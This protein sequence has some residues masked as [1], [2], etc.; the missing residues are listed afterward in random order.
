VDTDLIGPGYAS[1]YGLA[2][3]VHERPWPTKKGE[4]IYADNGVRTHG[5]VSYRTI[6]RGE[7]HGCHR[8]FNHQALRLTGF[9]LQHRP[10]RR[11]GPERVGYERRI[12]WRGRVLKLRVDDRGY[13]YTFDPPIPVEVLEGRLRGGAARPMAARA[14]D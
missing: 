1:A 13:G 5:S 10:H 12:P 2:M 8:L 6:G 11:D 7:S 3:L 4:T 9:L 14:G